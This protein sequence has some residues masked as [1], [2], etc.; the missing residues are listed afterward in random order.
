MPTAAQCDDARDEL[1]ALKSA[2]LGMYR[3]GAIRSV[4]SSSGKRLE[5]QPTSIRDLNARI[6]QLEATV[7]LCDGCGGRRVINFIPVTR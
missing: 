2:R 3:T 4:T 1:A 7:S 6:T 5:Y